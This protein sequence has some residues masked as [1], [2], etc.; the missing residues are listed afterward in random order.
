[1]VL[2]FK[3]QL[4]FQFCFHVDLFLTLIAMSLRLN[5]VVQFIRHLASCHCRV[6]STETFISVYADYQSAVAVEQTKKM[7][8]RMRWSR[9]G[10]LRHLGHSYLSNEIEIG[11]DGT[12]HCLARKRALKV[13]CSL[14]DLW[15]MQ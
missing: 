5:A 7:Y 3:S 13:L 6:G 15:T 14:K 10:M 4:D 9:L 8:I 12:V 11:E 1:M 2:G